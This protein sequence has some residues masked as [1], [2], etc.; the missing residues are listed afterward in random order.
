M[1]QEAFEPNEKR[2]IA[3]QENVSKY[4]CESIFS[5]FSEYDEQR[6]HIKL[7]TRK[8]TLKWISFNIRQTK[9]GMWCGWLS[10]NIYQIYP[11]HVHSNLLFGSRFPN[12]QRYKFISQMNTHA[13]TRILNT[14]GNKVFVHGVLFCLFQWANQRTE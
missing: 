3:K 1:L 8:S 2:K 10:L 5:G 14:T 13:H 7:W 12:S 9:W 6:L 11:S 4:V